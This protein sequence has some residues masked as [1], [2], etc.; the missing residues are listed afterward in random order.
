MKKLV[1]PLHDRKFAGVLSGIAKYV[2]MDATVVRL[3][4][5][6]LLLI[7]GVMPFALLYVLAIFVIPNEEIHT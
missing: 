5:I 2:Q 7:T 6:G 3:I 1:R 4:F